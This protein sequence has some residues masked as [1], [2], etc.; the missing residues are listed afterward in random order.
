MRIP[1]LACLALVVL[2]APGLS[3]CG[4][5][6]NPYSVQSMDISI[7]GAVLPQALSGESVNYVVPITGGCGG[8]YVLSIISG[9]LP[10]GLS[11]D[12]ATHAIRGTVL[13]PGNYSFTLQ[14]VD[15]GCTPFATTTRP[16]TWNINI[17]PVVIVSADPDI[18]PVADYN[19][20]FTTKFNDIDAL[21]TT[22]YGQ[23]AVFNFTVAG[24]VP[25]YTFEIIDDPN[26][27]Q[28]SNW[29]ATAMPQSM[30]IPPF[31]TSFLGQ[32]QQT[33]GSIPFRI[34]FRV[35]D[36]NNDIGIRKLQWRVDTP[37]IIIATT[38]LPN[39]KCGTVYNE[40]VQIVDGVPPFRFEL[41]QAPATV[42][43]WQSPL[44]PILNPPGITVDPVTG[45]ANNKCTAANYPA[46]NVAGPYSG[47][48]PE[49]SFLR[50]A[51]GTFG[52]IPRRLGAFTFHVHVNSTLVPNDFG[53]HAWQTYTTTFLNSEPP[54]A[55][56]P[57]FAFSNFA[58]WTVEGTLL[59]AAPWS[60]LPELERGVPYNPDGG[61]NG[62]SL[63]AQGGVPKDGLTDGPHIS[64]VSNID[65]QLAPPVQ[66]FGGGY[67]WIINWDPVGQGTVQ[68]AGV[69]FRTWLGVLVVPNP[70]LLVSQ[71]RTVIDVACLDQ[72]LPL[73]SRHSITAR[74]AYSIGPDRVLFTES[75]RSE[76]LNRPGTSFNDHDQT[77]RV[78]EPLS[79]GVIFRDLDNASD[80]TPQGLPGTTATT[81]VKDLF[82]E[83][84][85]MRLNVNPT[86]WWQD[87]HGL[88]PAGARGAQ[89]S[90]P[91]KGA[92]FY[93]SDYED[94]TYAPWNPDVSHVRLPFA[95]GVVPNIGLGVYADGGKM[96]AFENAGTF[97]ILIV[98]PDSRLYVP[99]A[100][101]LS[102][103]YSGFGDSMM[104]PRP[105]TGG[106]P[107]HGSQRIPHITISPNGRFAAMKLRTNN[108]TGGGVFFET[109]DS[110]KILLFSL[111]GETVFGGS[112]WT[113]VDT[114]SD[115]SQ[116]MGTWFY[117][118]SMA[119]TDTY[120]YYVCGNHLDY[121]S[122]WREHGVYR[123]T[124][125][126]GAGS[127]ALLAP[128]AFP[129]WRN[130][131][132]SPSNLMQTAFHHM[133]NPIT[134]QSQ[135]V[136][137]GSSWTF[138][139]TDILNRE[140]YGYDGWN[141]TE[142]SVAP[143]PFRVSKSGTSCAILAGAETGNPGADANNM[144]HHVWVDHNGTLRQ[145][146]TVRRHSPQGGARGYTLSRGPTQ[147]RH[148]GAFTGP[149]TGFEISDN[150]TKIAVVCNRQ[151]GVVDP[152]RYNFTGDYNWRAT[153]QDIVAFSTTNSWASA[154][155]LQ[156]TGTESATAPLFGGTAV[157][158]FGALVFTA[159][160]AGLVFWGGYNSQYRPATTLATDKSSQLS[161]TF[162]S[163]N[164]SN[165]ELKSILPTASGGSNTGSGLQTFTTASPVN[166]TFA[167][168]SGSQGR[169][170]PNGG[171]IS[172]NRNFLYITTHAA[173][174]ASDPSNE[175]LIGINIRSLNNAASINTR[176][177]GQAFK[178]AGQ[179]VM[180]GFLSI[181]DVDPHYCFE[182]RLYAPAHHQGFSSQ[183]MARDSGY[184]FFASHFQSN[185]QQALPFASGSP[186]FQTQAGPDHP[187]GSYDYGVWDGQVEG[188]SADVAG[189]VSRMTQTSLSQANSTQ[190]RPIHYI[191]TSD[192][193]R[194]LAFVYDTGQNTE[195]TA[196]QEA[197][198]F[199]QRIGF[200]PS[201][202]V[203]LT[204]AGTK[205]EWSTSLTAGRAGEAMAID[206]GGSRLYAAFGPTSDE[207]VK[208]IHEVRFNSSGAG[209][210]TVSSLGP[211]MRYNVLHAGR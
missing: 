188:F 65:G 110:T 2:A 143:V 18:I 63:R 102:S 185:T 196:G 76:T 48:I 160:N 199:I 73:A 124:I 49:G 161:G 178:V 35:I 208:N 125:T 175:T 138:A 75:T 146:S 130:D 106:T 136:Q 95:T 190:G 137:Q 27:P 180:R 38:T 144:N 184:V 141:G 13:L 31:S 158:R 128:N 181:Y 59:A 66:E 29:G 176:P 11:L 194:S 43:T 101:D 54:I 195:F 92:P 165:S 113:I 121:Y 21:R 9:Q 96:Y 157:W 164:F 82:T 84:D 94:T 207:N 71:S 119:M 97:G 12:D 42:D 131:G 209:S 166:P 19:P 69:E 115:G 105:V 4:G 88:N 39:G 7:D 55:P 172:R 79:S 15:T 108:N 10:P 41:T 135:F 183:V 36:S 134:T 28:D 51:T 117:A 174:S 156:V 155:T 40:G 70:S 118:G 204:G 56:A 85:L 98:R 57:A 46:Q 16:F 78:L 72:Q 151:T 109:A 14:I 93:A 87:V 112:V 104:Q 152:D 171:F 205:T 191:V 133:D 111:T 202:G 186:T 206:S 81:D 197:V 1:S 179:S 67:D 189:P 129:A 187:S 37:P 30:S 3:A 103:P 123:Y 64:Q 132:S 149:T 126:G 68:P 140:A 153:R 192:D 147:H 32:A 114:G 25:P 154:T 169:I 203:L 24:G 139:V 211:T 62:L 107:K 89:G 198:G 74:V 44:A 83:V 201:T 34:T 23:Q 170:R 200:D 60:T 193:G 90:D 120:L 86:G 163:Y 145:V 53:Q 52:G 33:N 210:F 182:E 58:S 100:F 150:A 122:S 142:N 45:A 20:P 116:N 159:D 127:G 61:T 6:G 22:V 26:D 148:W 99:V 8:P 47:I 177:D 80:L 167:A 17:G 91:N 173:V 50:E 162:Y 77:L 5:S 168:L